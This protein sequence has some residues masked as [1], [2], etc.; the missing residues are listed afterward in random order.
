MEHSNQAKEI[1]VAFDGSGDVRTVEDALQIAPPGATL[2]LKA[3]IH[4]LRQPLTL[5]HPITLL[6]E[7]MVNTLLV[8]DGEGYVVRYVGEGPFHACDLTFAHQ[9]DRWADVVV[10]E[11]GEVSLLRC[12]FTGGVR[13]SEAEQGGSGLCL[14]G[15]VRGTV[16]ECEA[17]EN[18]ANGIL[19]IG[20]AQA[21]LWNNTC[22]QNKNAGI[23]YC[24]C[25]SG[26]IRNNICTDNQSYGIYVAKHAQPTL[27]RNICLRN[28]QAGVAYFGSSGGCAHSNT[29]AENGIGIAVDEY[30]QP[31]LSKN[32]CSRNKNAGIAY[33]ECSAGHAQDNICSNNQYYGIYITDYAQPTLR[34]NICQGNSLY[35][36]AD[37]RVV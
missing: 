10:V 36:I 29:C 2:R 19:I 16:A 30:A 9:S 15:E 1:V 5:Q 24:S 31:T 4:R 11:Q 34:R 17:L 20:R 6:G 3:G 26:H 14:L 18:R 37:L 33:F 13:D 8:C 22:S 27:E 28:P 7:G 12:R 25:T 35:E 23:I 21:T 32:I